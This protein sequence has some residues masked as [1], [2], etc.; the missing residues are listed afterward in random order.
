MSTDPSTGRPKRIPHTEE[1]RALAVAAV[2][3][4][5]AAGESMTAAASTVSNS[6]GAGVTSIVRWC[7]AAGVGDNDA[8]AARDRTWQHRL[9]VVNK[10]NR[11]LTD[12]AREHL[13]GSSTAH[14]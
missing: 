9:D 2:R 11:D 4:L 1:V 10:L 8:L 12:A 13:R 7:R 6:T 5:M 3:E 14:G